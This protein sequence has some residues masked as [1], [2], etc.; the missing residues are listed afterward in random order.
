[1]AKLN[2]VRTERPTLNSLFGTLSEWN[3]DL[4]QEK[5]LFAEVGFELAANHIEPMP[6]F[7]LEVPA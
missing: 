7:D 2:M 1:M 4:Q 6:S 5:Q 3:A